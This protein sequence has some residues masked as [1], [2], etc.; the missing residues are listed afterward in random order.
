MLPSRKGKQLLREGAAVVHPLQHLLNEDGGLRV[1]RIFGQLLLQEPRARRDDGEQI[2]EIMGDAGNK[3]TDRLQL[4]RLA[5]A[6]LPR[7]LNRIV[8]ELISKGRV[9]T[10]GIGIITGNEEL[11]ARFGLEGVI[12]LR[13]TP[14]SPAERAGLRGVDVTAG[15]IGDVIVG[16]QGRPVRRLA[17]LTEVLEGLKLPAAVELTV[18]RGSERR[19][20]MVEVVDIGG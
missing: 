9:P 8:P 5:Q 13:P 17:D 15:T 3:P 1:G 19:T 16:V 2:V 10:P 11:A 6:L 18:L 20:V 4:L 12:I 14:G 7:A